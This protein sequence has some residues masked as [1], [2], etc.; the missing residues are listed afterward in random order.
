MAKYLAALLV[1]WT[2][3]SGVGMAVAQQMLSPRQREA[4]CARE[5]QKRGLSGK[6]FNEYMNRCT[7][8]GSRRGSGLA[9]PPASN[10]A[11]TPPQ[12]SAPAP[13]SARAVE[14]D[15]MARELGITGAAATS[16]LRRCIAR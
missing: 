10:P 9:P 12:P 15:R 3:L 6:S 5:A 8:L 11:A 4:Y 14:C 7:H 16:Y 1:G 13:R 2:V